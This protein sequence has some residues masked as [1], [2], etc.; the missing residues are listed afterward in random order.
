MRAFSPLVKR[1]RQTILLVA[2]AGAAQISC[3]D[4]AYAAVYATQ[5]FYFIDSIGVSYGGFSHQLIDQAISAA[6]GSPVGAST[7]FPGGGL[8]TQTTAFG[9]G[10]AGDANNFIL[11]NTTVIPGIFS[12]GG[13]NVLSI[14]VSSDITK[15]NLTLGTSGVVQLDFSSLYPAGVQVGDGGAMNYSMIQLIKPADTTAEVNLSELEVAVARTGLGLVAYPTIDNVNLLYGEQLP[16]I[17]SSGSKGWRYFGKFLQVCGATVTGAVTGGCA[18]GAVGAAAG[19]VVGGVPTGGVGAAPGAVTG[20]VVGGVIGGVGGGVGGGLSKAG[21]VIV[22]NNKDNDTNPQSP[23][24]TSSL[25]PASGVPSSGTL[26]NVP[27]PLPIF[28]TA[29]A[30]GY[31]RKLRKRIKNSKLPVASAID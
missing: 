23:P 18:G 10:L 14:L 17:V 1:L 27:G 15:S 20:A 11:E 30:F 5:D 21:D 19:A 2:C 6:I 26:Y 22:E 7:I 29:A 8:F 16:F 13:M 9:L 25:T 4:S 28:G 12:Y 3:A 24:K 31:S